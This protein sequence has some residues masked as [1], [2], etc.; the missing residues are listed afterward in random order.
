L[1]GIPNAPYRKYTIVN[2]N[3]LEKHFNPNDIIDPE[4]L[5]KKKIIKK[6]KFGVKILGDG[7]ITKPLIVKAHSFSASAREKIERAGGKVEVIK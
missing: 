7:E 1:G 6:I 3:V 2:L 5:L 4:I